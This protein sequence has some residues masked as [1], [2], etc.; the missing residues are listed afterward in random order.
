M[1]KQP[2]TVIY[3]FD[4]TLT[5]YSMPQYKIII[6]LGYLDEVLIPIVEQTMTKDNINIY[7]AYLKVINEIL[8]TNKI[9][10]KLE[11]ITKDA[12]AL[13]YNKGVVDYF[14]SLKDKNINNYVLTS[15]YEEYI[16][17]TEIGKYLKD[18]FGTKV[19]FTTTSYKINKLVTDK[20]KETILKNFIKENNLD[21][22]KII[23]VGDGITDYYAFNYIHNNGGT[24]ILITSNTNNNFKYNDIIDYYFKNDYSKDSEIVNYI[25]KRINN[26]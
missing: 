24:T 17:K 23:Y 22:K 26:L 21:F 12:I 20:D 15:G 16:R 10:N 4:G 5:P 8:T 7:E 25:N 6:D 18:V 13:T 2:L 3:D 1:N 9:N 11:A 14:K 19:T